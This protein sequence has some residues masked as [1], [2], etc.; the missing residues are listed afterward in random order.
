MFLVP[1]DITR[2]S[3]AVKVDAELVSYRSLFI[4]HPLTQCS[5][6]QYACA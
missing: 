6:A 2:G 4:E 5:D 1:L 3:L